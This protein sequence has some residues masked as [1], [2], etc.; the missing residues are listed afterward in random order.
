MTLVLLTLG[1]ARACLLSIVVLT[2]TWLHAVSI[3][4]RAVTIHKVRV[5]GRGL[6]VYELQRTGTENQAGQRDSIENV[7]NMQWRPASQKPV[8]APV[9]CGLSSSGPAQPNNETAHYY[10]V[11]RKRL[12]RPLNKGY[13]G[14]LPRTHAPPHGPSAPD[15]RTSGAIGRA[16]HATILDRSSD[17]VILASSVL[18]AVQPIGIPNANR[19]RYSIRYFIR[20]NVII[21]YLINVRLK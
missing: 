13:G 18:A 12:F 10:Y 21:G 15:P 6:P 8:I 4:P 14:P 19:I 3:C 7:G 2:A 17:T 16:L 11:H 20:Y 9:A 1:L 5:N